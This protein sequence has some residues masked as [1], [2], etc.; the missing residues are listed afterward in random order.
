MSAFILEDLD[1]LTKNCRIAYKSLPNK[2]D[3]P[4]SPELKSLLIKH[5]GSNLEISQY[6]IEYTNNQNQYGIFPSKWFW[7]ASIFYKLALAYG[8]YGEILTHLKG[9]QKFNDKDFLTDYPFEQEP[10]S[11]TQLQIEFEQEAQ[12]FITSKDPSTASQNFDLF[13]KFIYKKSWWNQGEVSTKKDKSS[14]KNFFRSNTDLFKSTLLTATQFIVSTSDKL[15]TLIYAVAEEPLILN[16]LKNIINNINASNSVKTS[17]IKLGENII[18]YGAP[19]TGKS[20]EINELTKKN[21]Y[22]VRTVFHPDTQYSDFVGCLRPSM[23]S[24]GIEYSYKHGPF[25]EALVKALNDPAHHYY[26]IIEELNRAPAAAVFGE[27]FQLLDREDGQS[28]YK[29]DINDKDLLKLLNIELTT[30]LTNNKLY[31]PK[32]LSIYA[33]MNSSD[34]AVMPL[35]TAFKRRWKFEYKPISFEDKDGKQ[36]CPK[37]TIKFQTKNGPEEIEWAVL[38]QTIN[39]IL[40]SESIPEDRHLGPWFVNK[41]ELGN[42]DEA[43]K[44]FTGKILMYLWDDVLR[45]GETSKLFHKDIKTFGGLISAHEKNKLIFSE[46]FYSI[47]E[48]TYPIKTTATST[49]SSDE[50]K[51]ENTV[52]A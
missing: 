12:S 42:P 1:Q 33:T 16:E 14:G 17:S 19:G 50:V 47:L 35:D 6:S 5:L 24:S 36:G 25:I 52:D 31:I 29:I 22:S 2:I 11:K 4:I 40:S 20:H 10:S 7:V 46:K 13:K 34:Q 15:T 9:L 44:C 27:I 41:D 18:Y 38:A 26:L 48:E 28:Q 3:I 8:P 32:N 45:H 30:P 51:E 43:Q 21:N 37:G 23:G 39:R 49:T